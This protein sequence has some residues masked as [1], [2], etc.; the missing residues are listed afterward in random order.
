[1]QRKGSRNEYFQ[2]R[3]PA[4]VKQAAIG[5]RLEF[6]CRRGDGH[7]C[8][9]QSAPHRSSF[10]S[11]PSIPLRS[12]CDRRRRRDRRSC[13]GRR[14]RQTKAVTLSH[15]QCVALAGRAYQGWTSGER[16]ETTT[17]ME[18][19]PVLA[20]RSRGRLRREWRWEPTGAATMEGEP[21]VWAA[22]AKSVDD[23]EKLGALADRLLR[24]EGID[25]LDGLDGESREMLLAEIAKALKDALAARQRNADGDYRSDPM[26][27]RF[28]SL[29]AACPSGIAPS[30]LPLPHRPRPIRSPSWDWSKIGGAR[31]RLGACRSAR[32]KLS[33]HGEEV[34]VVH[35]AR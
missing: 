26:A 6:L 8:L 10:P 9:S 25:G 30:S 17:A 7:H 11:A 12:R 34:R 22:A 19:V 20:G 4:D 16:R 24:A 5:W 15:R 1:M 32:I 23:P 28:P 21:D 18:R 13:I 31:L 27:E 29:D 14:L 33:E 2:Q 35:Q 3:I